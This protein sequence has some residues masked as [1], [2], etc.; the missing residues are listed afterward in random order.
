MLSAAPCPGRCGTSGGLPE[1]R[2]LLKLLPEELG[3]RF[4][5]L[6]GARNEQRV[7]ALQPVRVAGPVGPAPAAVDGEGVHP[8]LGLD[9]EGVQRLAV[10]WRPRGDGELQYDLV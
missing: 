2:R 1:L 7:A 5:A 3:E 6:M 4:E 9:L 10:G 8:C